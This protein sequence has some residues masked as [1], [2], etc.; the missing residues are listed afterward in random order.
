MSIICP[1]QIIPFPR[2]PLYIYLVLI[3]QNLKI[4]KFLKEL[5]LS[6]SQRKIQAQ[7]K[8][9]EKELNELKRMEK[10][11]LTRRKKISK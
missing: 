8:R 10:E 5:I 11:Q 7:N 3:P 4:V 6:S 2:N 1:W 9:L